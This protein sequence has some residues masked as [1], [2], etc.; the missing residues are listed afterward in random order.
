MTP[1]APIQSALSPPDGRQ[2]VIRTDSSPE[3]LAAAVEFAEAAAE[4]SRW[5]TGDWM[6]DLMMEARTLVHRAGETISGRGAAEGE[7]KNLDRRLLEL[8]G[9][10]R[11]WKGDGEADALAKEMHEMSDA[12]RM[13]LKENRPPRRQRPQ[14]AEPD[15]MR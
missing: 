14:E 10:L 13:A 1:T 11:Q 8:I 5:N 6:F 12:I 7:L 15:E 4:S 3:Y 2:I 9:R